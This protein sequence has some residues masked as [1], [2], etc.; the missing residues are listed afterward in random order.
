[1]VVPLGRKAQIGRG[2][3][4]TTPSSA[5]RALAGPGAAKKPV[6]KVAKRDE[7]ESGSAAKPA[8]KKPAPKKPAEGKSDAKKS[9]SASGRRTAPKRP[10]LRI[11]PEPGSTAADAAEETIR[12]DAGTDD[13]PF[14]EIAEAVLAGVRRIL[15]EDWQGRA[16]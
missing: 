1:N 8:A 9:A 16:E 3:A 10:R 15:G 7:E 13:L 14:E 2:N 5:A 11:A 4:K 12:P 6:R